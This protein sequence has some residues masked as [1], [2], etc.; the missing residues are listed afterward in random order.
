MKRKVTA[1]VLSGG[2]N[3]GAIQAG[4]LLALFEQG[5]KVDMLVGTS[6]G[7]MNAGF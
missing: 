3:R 1:V 6:V 4:A 5:I 7:A 2:G